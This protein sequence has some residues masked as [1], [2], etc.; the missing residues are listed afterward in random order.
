MHLP[1]KVESEPMASLI[2]KNQRSPASA[3]SCEQ[4]FED[5]RGVLF[6]LRR[7]LNA[8]RHASR[9]SPVDADDKNDK[10][11]GDDGDDRPTLKRRPTDN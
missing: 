8:E 1:G 6:G 4:P 2:L 7:D 3:A 9:A 10:K 11:K 5:R